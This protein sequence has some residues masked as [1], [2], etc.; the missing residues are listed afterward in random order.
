MAFTI[1][2]YPRRPYGMTFFGGQEGSAGFVDRIWTEWRR[3][4]DETL[5]P[6]LDFSEKEGA[7]Y[8]TAELPGIKKEDITVCINGGYVTV[9]G[10]KRQ[11]SADGDADYFM[12]E[13]KSGTFSRRIRLPGKVDEHKADA[14]YQD[15]VLT[16]VIP[17]KKDPTF[18]KVE[19]R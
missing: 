9:S 4:R 12:R 3:E 16:V 8:I 19:I 2:K 6:R 18:L 5:S 15:G 7:Y 14:A 10:K 11:K 13:T 17:K 1:R